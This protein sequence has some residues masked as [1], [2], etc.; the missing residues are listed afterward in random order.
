[1][2]YLFIKKYKYKVLNVKGMRHGLRK[3][4]VFGIYV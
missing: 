2:Y 3:Q 1:V 4:V